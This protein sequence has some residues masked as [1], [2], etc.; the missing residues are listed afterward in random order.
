MPRAELRLSTQL[1]WTA[2]WRLASRNTTL[3]TAL[4]DPCRVTLL[5]VD[6][7]PL[8]RRITDAQAGRMARLVDSLLPATADLRRAADSLWRELQQPVPVDSAG[9]LWLLTSPES[10]G[11]VPLDGRGASIRTGLTLVARPRIVAGAR[12]V[13]VVR[14]LPALTLARAADGLRIPVQ[15]EVPFDEV[16]RRAT[17]LLAARTAGDRVRVRRVDMSGAGDSAVV[18][19][20]LEGA[21]DGTLQLVGRPRYDAATRTLVVDDLDYTVESRGIVSRLAAT[22]GAPLVRRAIDE[23]TNGGRVALGPQLDATRLALTRQLNRALTADVVMGG[24]IR[25][26]TVTGVHASATG[27]VVRVLLEGEA[28]LWAR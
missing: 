22:L 4:P 10:V 21:I 7:T 13:V 5:G 9:T 26:L 24:G 23:A 27:F 6:A 15:V 17:A 8:M 11:L 14:A 1:Y 19:L 3:G 18:R 25:T 20:A 12:P 16:G 2:D 28:G